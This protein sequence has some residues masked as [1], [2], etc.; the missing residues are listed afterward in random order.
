MPTDL[1]N[2]YIADAIMKKW[3]V[4]AQ[5]DVAIEE[6]AELIV[7]LATLRGHNDIREI[8]NS[9]KTMTKQIRANDHVAGERV[10]R[11]QATDVRRRISEE[12][13]DVHIMME[14]LI[15]VFVLWPEFNKFHDEK[16]NRLCKR[17]CG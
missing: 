10:E 6:C 5:V 12:I 8:A 7:E 14:Q 17:L 9:I 1:I 4:T 11:R 13:A 3:G 15:R 2:D 16:Y